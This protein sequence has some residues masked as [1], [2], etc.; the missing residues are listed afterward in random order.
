MV[1]LRG[2]HA[3]LQF[4]GPTIQKGSSAVLNLIT[5]PTELQGCLNHTHSRALTPRFLSESYRLWV[6]NHSQD[7]DN[8]PRH[9]TIS[10]IARRLDRSLF[11]T[12]P[13][14]PHVLTAA[15]MVDC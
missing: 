14:S 5:D 11:S 10:T 3:R 13:L 7:P 12:I 2:S 15:P 1:V 4:T 8:K 6:T 9:H